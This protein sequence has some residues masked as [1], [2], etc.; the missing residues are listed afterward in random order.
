TTQHTLPYTTLFRSI[1]QS[2]KSVA[3]TLRSLELS[4]ATRVSL[5]LLA[6]LD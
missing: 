4:K 6:A 3:S 1:K 2:D 5:P